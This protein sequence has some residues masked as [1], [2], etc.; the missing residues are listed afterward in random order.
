MSNIDRGAKRPCWECGRPS[1][2]HCT[3]TSTDDLMCGR[4]L[5]GRCHDAGLCKEHASPAGCPE[6][7]HTLWRGHHE[8]GRAPECIW[9]AKRYMESAPQDRVLAWPWAAAPPEL[10]ELCDF[11]SHSAWVAVVPK[12]WPLPPWALQSE[13]R[14]VHR[15]E[16]HRVIIAGGQI[17][18]RYQTTDEV[19]R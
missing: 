6:C 3:H 10:R 5:C 14:E 15:F 13:Y 4:P 18:G 17:G 1:W 8:D 19:T 2:T 11:P 7:G 12:A 9:P 16:R